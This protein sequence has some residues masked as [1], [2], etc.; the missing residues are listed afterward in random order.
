MNGSP[1]PQS[2]ARSAQERLITTP[3]VASFIGAA[4]NGDLYD[5]DQQRRAAAWA[6]WAITAL[7]E[8]SNGMRTYPVLKLTGSFYDPYGNGPKI[9]PHLEIPVRVLRR[10]D[11]E[12][13]SRLAQIGNGLAFPY[14]VYSE[15]TAVRR[16]LFNTPDGPVGELCELLN[17]RR[18]SLQTGLESVS[19]AAAPRWSEVTA[20]IMS[21]PD[22]LSTDATGDF[23]EDEVSSYLPA[24][25]DLHLR[26][27]YDER[28]RT[29]SGAMA[30]R[31]VGVWQISGRTDGGDD[32]ALG[33]ITPRLTVNS[34]FKDMLFAPERESPAALLVRTLLLRRVLN[35]H[36]GASYG[37]Q[38][39]G[40]DPGTVVAP[41]KPGAYLRAVVSQPGHK[42]PEASV[43]AAAGLIEAYPD[44]EAAWAAL[45][46]WSGRGYLL[47]VTRE[48]FLAAHRSVSRSLARVE[49]V[50]R[51]AIDCLL[52]LAWDVR[53]GKAR[54]VRVTFTRSADDS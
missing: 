30:S 51:G 6:T 31:R 41:R 49:D 36:L 10:A 14:W 22:G 46:R 54:V 47:T 43:E 28:L 9:H 39:G 35:R 40:P 25:A 17:E 12:F 48:G 23:T 33:V 8:A 45:D 19:K 5:R 50:D 15:V 16:A 34:L 53:E 24:A 37:G 7:G 26:V 21:D 18:A 1:D 38:V 42:L 11:P 29:K 32:F 2:A 44:P 3:F 27:A 52:P 13:P 20:L 4:R